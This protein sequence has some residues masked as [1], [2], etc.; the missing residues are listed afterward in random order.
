MS[1]NPT[2][3][4]L[5]EMVMFVK[6]VESGS[7]SEAA[8]QLGISPSAASRGVSRL[9]KGL[10]VQLLQRTTRKLRLSESGKEIY[11]CCCTMV[12]SA[13]TVLD[14]SAKYSQ[15]PEGLIRISAPKSLGRF[16][17][18]PLIPEFLRQYPGIDVHLLLSDHNCDLIDGNLDLAV[19]LTQ[20]PPPGLVGR[21]LLPISQ[22]LCAS[23]DYLVEHGAPGHPADLERHFCIGEGDLN[24]GARWQLRNGSELVKLQ[25][26][27][28]YSINHCE[29]RLDAVLRNLGI[30]C[31]PM[32]TAQ[33]ELRRGRIIQLLPEWDFSSVGGQGSAWLL[34]HPTDYLPTRVR[35]L[36][37]YLVRKVRDDEGLSGAVHLPAPADIGEGSKSK[38]LVPVRIH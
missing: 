22:V 35:A 4:L 37:D 17:I 18:H 38:A 23:P 15:E 26:P 9:E 32:F 5:E 24:H 27:S 14:M 34:Y 6:V 11:R 33:E 19:H 2:M 30:A 20:Q 28:R 1:M 31:L 10:S 16:I 36:I 3:M 8:R 7:F 12:S 25:V 29:G 21:S 13:K